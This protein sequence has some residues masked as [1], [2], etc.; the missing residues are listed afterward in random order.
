MMRRAFVPLAIV[1]V[2]LLGWFATDPGPDT[3]GQ[4]ATPSPAS[5][6][7]IGAWD[8]MVIPPHGPP[9]SGVLTFAA[10]GTLTAVDVPAPSALPDELATAVIAS[11]GQGTWVTT[12]PLGQVA[13]VV[14]HVLVSS[15]TGGPVGTLTLRGT[16]VRDPK[17]RT[18]S[19]S[20]D[21]AFADPLGRAASIGPGTFYG[22]RFTVEP[23]G[24]PVAS[25]P[26]ASTPGAGTPTT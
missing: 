2:A 10:D 7:F 4:A 20:Y 1:T 8:I 23:P 22:Q 14:V 9:H 25:T 12:G 19:A 16:A 15:E 6:G 21:L 5:G 26:T 11:D 17:G 13:V 3:A 18:L 24:T